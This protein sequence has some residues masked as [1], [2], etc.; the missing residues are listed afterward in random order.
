[1]V[2]VDMERV[3]QVAED[4]DYIGFCRACGAECDGVEWDARGYECCDCGKPTVFGILY[5]LGL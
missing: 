3:L 5:W 1:M 4:D 2:T